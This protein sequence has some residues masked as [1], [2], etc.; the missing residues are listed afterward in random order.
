M[1][2]YRL[3]CDCIYQ[4][5][6]TQFWNF[7]LNVFPVQ[8][9]YGHFLAVRESDSDNIGINIHVIVSAAVVSGGHRSRRFVPETHGRGLKLKAGV[10]AA[11]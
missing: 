7:Y 9:D 11:D 5:P 4:L 10:R 3:Q 6:F 1:H 8:G 2:N